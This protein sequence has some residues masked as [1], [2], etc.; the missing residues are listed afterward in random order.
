MLGC[1]GMGWDRVDGMGKDRPWTGNGRGFEACAQN[2][3]KFTKMDAENK[4]MHSSYSVQLRE[5]GVPALLQ[6]ST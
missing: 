2:Q 3:K 1:R 5:S 4:E 6:K